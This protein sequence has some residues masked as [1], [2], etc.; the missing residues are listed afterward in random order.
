MWLFGARAGADGSCACSRC[1]RS[2]SRAAAAGYSAFLFGQAEGRD[3]WQSPLLL[4]QLLVAALAAGA[5]SLLVVRVL[6]GGDA[7]AYGSSRLDHAL[8]ALVGEAALLFAELGG[9]HAERR[10]RAR[11]RLITRG[12][13]SGRFWGGV[14]VAGI[15]VPLALRLVFDPGAAVAFGGA[16]RA[17]GAVDLR[18][19][20]GQGRPER[21]AELKGDPRD[22]SDR[23]APASVREGASAARRRARQLSA[24]RALG[25]LGG[26]RPDAWPRKVKRRYSLI[27]TIC[28]NC[29]AAC[30]LL[31]YVDQ[32]TR[33]DPEVRGQPDAPG[34]PRPQLRQGPG[35][36]QPGRR[37]RAHPLSA[38][39][40]GRARRRR[41]G[42]RDAGTRRSTT[43][44]GA[45]A[46][47]SSR[48]GRRK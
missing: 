12:H 10:R 27:P 15:V 13:F 39:P 11:R 16:A 34:Q 42:A 37:S 18:G 25:R 47:R 24:R 28:F 41:V 4:P 14:I 29:E 22:A 43:S 48:A 6:A 8:V 9:K 38:A 45:S 1:R 31:A 30:G 44:P 19:R 17:R 7:G 35:D 26:V 21:A 3:F 5:G 23:R 20:L 40:Q 36:A 46:R 33:Q 32:T 2:S